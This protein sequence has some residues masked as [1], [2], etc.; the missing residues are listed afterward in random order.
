M[1]DNIKN[2]V[3]GQVTAVEKAPDRRRILDR[4]NL[5]MVW[6]E[7]EEFEDVLVTLETSCEITESAIVVDGG[8]QLRV[9]NTV[10]MRGIG[11]MGSGP[12]VA[13]EEVAK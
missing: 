11:Y 7:T 10:H 1:A 13:I 8:F 9:G 3:I 12:V 4:E 6:V 5:R 2:Y